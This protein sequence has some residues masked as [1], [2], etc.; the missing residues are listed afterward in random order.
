MKN[1]AHN[2]RGNMNSSFS[3]KGTML[4]LEKHKVLAGKIEEYTSNNTSRIA[5]Y[6]LP[7]EEPGQS[8]PCI[9]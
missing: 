7:R 4:C 9:T 5:I 8:I 6:T 3:E 2:F 1:K